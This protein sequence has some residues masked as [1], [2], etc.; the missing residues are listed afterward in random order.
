MEKAVTGFGCGMAG[1]GLMAGF[2]IGNGWLWVAGL[3]I[4]LCTLGL[5]FWED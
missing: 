5:M 2:V 3:G 1:L 4:A